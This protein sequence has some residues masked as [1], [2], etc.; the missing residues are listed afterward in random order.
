MRAQALLDEK[1]AVLA[2][3]RAQYETAMRRKQ[4]LVDD[5]D[6][7]RRRMATATTLI[8]GLSGE[9]IRWTEETR[10]LRDQVNRLVGDVLLATAFLSYC[11]PFNQDFR[12]RLITSWF[13]ELA[14]RHVAHTVNLDLI[15]MLTNGPMVTV[16]ALSFL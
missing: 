9:K 11:G 8:E 14:T 1:E 10:T 12:H 5:A 16:T 6:A 2:E 13:R 4:D 7:C 15:N 3:V